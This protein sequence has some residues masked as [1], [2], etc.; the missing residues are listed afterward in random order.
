MS[1]MPGDTS[2]RCFNFATRDNFA[3]P[4]SSEAEPEQQQQLPTV[5]ALQHHARH[6][7]LAV[8]LS[9]GDVVCL[10][11]SMQK[12]GPSAAKQERAHT[13]TV[14]SEWLLQASVKLAAPAQALDFGPSG[15][16]F[17]AV[18]SR[19]I[20]ICCESALATAAHGQL[21]A[22]QTSAQQVAIHHHTK[23]L[24]RSAAGLRLSRLALS[25]THL[26]I[27]NDSA[28]DIFA[29]D[30]AD[31]ARAAAISL[32]GPATAVTLLAQTM[33]RINGNA[34]QA[35]DM[36]GNL[37]GSVDLPVDFGKVQWLCS[38][39][40][41]LLAVSSS[42]KTGRYSVKGG[43]LYEATFSQV[44]QPNCNSQLA[45]ARL[46]QLICRANV[47]GHHCWLCNSH[48]HTLGAALLVHW[49][50]TCDHIDVQVQA[51]KEPKLGG[52][53]LAALSSDGAHAALLFNATPANTGQ[54]ATVVAVHDLQAEH[55]VELGAQHLLHQSA[56]C[57]L[58]R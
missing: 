30:A 33:Y 32:T 38:S 22:V 21:V 28:A 57:T 13:A 55:T 6:N 39:G 35:L 31:A 16:I 51:S 49:A 54:L 43:A 42:L 41:T 24:T 50:V 20:T 53:G 26:A 40:N 48:D 25:K 14:R 3:L 18:T 45:T 17:S 9:S 37:R 23:G 36:A 27:W 34:I 15:R 10:S 7:T 5:V 12:S 29:L 11:R 46:Q 1:A 19:G 2:V 56:S 52:V 58:S 4:L 44:R 47:C 8:S